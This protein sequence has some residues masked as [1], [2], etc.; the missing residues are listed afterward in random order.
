MPRNLRTRAVVVLVVLL[1]SLWYLYPPKK[2]INLGLDLQ[3]GI[4]LVLGV[5]TDKHVASQT[6]RAAEDFKAALERRGIAAK[7]VAREGLASFVVELA[8]PQ[9]WNDAL[10]VAGEFQTFDRANEDQAAGRFTL[11]MQS[12]VIARLR[13][14]AVRQGVETIRNRVDQFGVAEPTI[15]RQGDERI[16]IQLPG[17]QDPE[18]AKALIGKTALLEFK[19]VDEKA[20]RSSTSAAWTSRR[21]PSARSR[22]SSTSGRC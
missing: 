16:L 13:D 11:T 6:D 22:T 19:L 2:A 3:G 15:T 8:S 14:D 7:R 12:R 1:G 21:R 18:R 5:E 9:S 20:T 17:V 10:S 4:H